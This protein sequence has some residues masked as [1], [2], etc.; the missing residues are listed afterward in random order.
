MGIRVVDAVSGNRLGLIQA[1]LRWAVAIL[2][3]LLA[4]M[5]PEWPGT[6]ERMKALAD[7]Q[8]RIDELRVE[9]QDDPAALNQALMATYRQHDLDPVT[10]CTGTLPG[11]LVH[12]VCGWVVYRGVLRPPLHQGLHDRIAN[13]VVVRLS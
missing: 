4:D 1:V 2:P 3:S 12:L 6:Q 13:A 10:G 7:L 11:P 9:H 8:P 5:V